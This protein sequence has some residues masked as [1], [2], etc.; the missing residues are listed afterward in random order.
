M[1]FGVQE[2]T[3]RG[4]LWE[5]REEPVAVFEEPIL[6][7]CVEIVPVLI[8]PA[9]VF[10]CKRRS[11]QCDPDNLPLSAMFTNHQHEDEH[12]LRM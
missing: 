7:D 9:V 3:L 4:Q 12:G 11:G 1:G 8:G 10:L 2:A 5:L 6:V